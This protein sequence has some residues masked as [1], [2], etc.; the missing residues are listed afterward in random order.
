MAGSTTS[1][2]LTTRFGDWQRPILRPN[3]FTMSLPFVPS[4]DRSGEKFSMPIMVAISQGATVDNTGNV[5]TLN[6]ARS[7][8]NLR[9]ELDGVNLYMQEQLSYSDLM[10]MSNGSSESGDAPSYMSG[11]EWVYY[12]MLL[13]LEHHA[14]IMSL[15]GA[16]TAAAIGCDIGVIDTTPVAS[17]G[18][19]YNSATNPVVRISSATWAKLMWLN[20]GGGGDIDKGMLVDIYQSDG[21]TL[22]TS[23]I[24]IVGVR[25]A[26]KCQVEMDATASSSTPGA[27]VTAGDR[28]VP[29]GWLGASALGVSGI[30]QTVGTFATIDNTSNP[31]WRCQPFD[32]GGVA[33]SFDLIQNFAAKLKGN[34]FTQGV[35]DVWCSPPVAAVLANSIQAAT[36]WV[37]GESQEKKIVGTGATEVVTQVGKFIFHNYGYIKQGEIL[38][39]ARGEWCRIGASEQRENGL[40]G[41]GLVL[42]LNNQSGSEMRAMSQ[43]APMPKKPIFSGRMFNFSVTS[44]AGFDIA[45][46]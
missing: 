32:C 41:E 23:N 11:P 31:H 9:A 43:F 42:E 40:K 26:N 4:A 2:L 22:R 15:Y 1:A 39:V 37:G 24:R 36:R 14:E 28:I 33:I 12:S 20:S 46:N 30:M 16:G 29:K 38:V 19:N 3:T 27:A 8:K 25:D 10:K 5:I 18:P 13:G 45:A 35:F 17:G 7:G 34:G 6:G 21:T 44:G